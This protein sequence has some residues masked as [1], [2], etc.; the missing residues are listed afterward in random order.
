MI[1]TINEFRKLN[2]NNNSNVFSE[3]EK[4]H[5]LA[6][7]KSNAKLGGSPQ[8]IK[9]NVYHFISKEEF[10]TMDWYL[11]KKND[12]FAL[13]MEELVSTSK[14]IVVVNNLSEFERYFELYENEDDDDDL[15]PAGGR[16]LHSHE[17]RKT[18]E[19]KSKSSVIK[20]LIAAGYSQDTAED[21]ADEYQQGGVKLPKKAKDIID[22]KTSDKTNE[23]ALKRHWEEITDAI[24]AHLPLKYKSGETFGEAIP[25]EYKNNVVTFDNGINVIDMYVNTTINN[26]NETKM[27]VTPLLWE[28]S[29]DGNGDLI[30]DGVD[31]SEGFKNRYLIYRYGQ[32]FILQVN[33][34]NKSRGPLKLVK[35]VAMQI[36]KEVQKKNPQ[37]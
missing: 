1:T 25:I 15:D 6:Y 34:K 13:F 18:N 21:F 10:G 11:I 23:G 36:E 22:G 27:I 14:P 4:N 9:P 28:Q 32:Q 12:K 17:S 31:N 33:G 35:A 7:C 30:A 20:K 37:M 5:L 16:G 24:A 3:E 8:F 19:K 26:I 2:E 29:S